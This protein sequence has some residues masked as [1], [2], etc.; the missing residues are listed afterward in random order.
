MLTTLQAIVL[1]LVEGVTEYLPVSSTGHL[2][3]AS[4][5]MGLNRDPG[6][7][8]AVDDFNIIIQG[9]AI[10]AVVGLYFPRF[11]QMLRGLLGKDPA[12]LRLLVNIGVAFTPAAAVGLLFDDAIEAALFKP[13]P[14]IGALI[15]GGLF[16]IALDVLVISKRRRGASSGG[17]GAGLDDVARMSPGQA[18]TVGLM[19]IAALWPGTSR[20]MMTIA[21]G[22]VSGLTPRAAAEFSF[23][24]GMPTLLAAT[25]YKLVKNLRHAAQTGEPTLFETLGWGPVLIGM[26]VAAVSAAVAVKWL[27]GFLNKHGLTPFGIYRILL[28]LL[29]IGAINRGMVTIEPEGAAAPASSVVPAATP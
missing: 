1:G 6:V 13:G 9:G 10:L 15:V 20:S 5:L 8:A 24:L 12:G 29:L 2:I 25:G 17:G 14:V 21:G 18:L 16:M 7:K 23:L 28:G 3:L 22:V 11:L 26:V 4:G 27:V 19:Q